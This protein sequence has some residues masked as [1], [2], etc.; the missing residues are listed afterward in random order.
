MVYA[1]CCVPVASLR[2]APSQASELS[3]Q[4]LFGECCKILL[5]EKGWVLVQCQYDGYEGWCQI[6][7][8]TEIT[9]DDFLYAKKDLAGGWVNDIIY[10]GQLMHIPFGSSLTGII[11]GKG[12]WKKNILKFSG[13]V[14]NISTAKNDT[15]L[16]K[17]IIFAYLNSPYLWGGKSVFGVDCSGF[18]QMVYKFFN[19][20]LPRDAQH[21][22]E[23]GE[24]IGFLQEAIL[25][26]L[27][28]FDNAEGNIIHA[29]IILGENEIIH[30]AGK[31]RI[32][33]IDAQGILNTDT[34][35]RTHNLRIIKRFF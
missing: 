24:A 32:D 17:E 2:L 8:L 27:A 23:K 5:N 13:R 28:F 20:V 9:V 34:G 7:Q 14:W 3:S 15:K 21:Q 10:N 25:G 11:N 33:K 30:A 35:E 1:V 12:E 18:T 6:N 29:G 4:L 26:D 19:I 31:V 16:L 22:V